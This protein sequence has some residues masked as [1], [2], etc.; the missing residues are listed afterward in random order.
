MSTISGISFDKNGVRAKLSN[1]LERNIALKFPTT[2]NRE[3]I[4][5][6]VQALIAR[7]PELWCMRVHIFSLRPL[8]YVIGVGE[9]IRFR[10]R[11]WE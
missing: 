2:G 4:A 8:K 9:S 5:A 6:A 10:D 11:W 7:H 1:G 3:I